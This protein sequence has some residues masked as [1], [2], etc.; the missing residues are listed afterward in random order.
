MVKRLWD[1]PT[2]LL[3]G[4][5]LN[6]V[7]LDASKLKIAAFDPSAISAGACY[8]DG[9][10][11]WSTQGTPA[12]V[13]LW[14]VQSGALDAHLWVFEEAFGMRRP[15]G[16]PGEVVDEPKGATPEDL[17]RLGRSAG[18]VEGFL[19]GALTW[20]K[21][22]PNAPAWRRTPTPPVWRPYPSVWRAEMGLNAK[23]SL[24]R[25]AREETAELCWRYAC[26]VTKRPLEGPM[27]GRNIDEAMAVCMVEA[28][29]GVAATV[30]LQRRTVL[31][32]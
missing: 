26:S 7:G 4:G 10:R 2:A 28:A 24:H 9:T 14:A 23:R 22:D 31:R 20:A 3:F 30:A 13:A 21:R 17:V 29:R 18:Y 11:S 8:H 19:A 5:P 12:H 6:A 25:T 32:A 16:K 27:G 15:S 1:E